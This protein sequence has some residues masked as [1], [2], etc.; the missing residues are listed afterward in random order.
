[1][2]SAEDSKIK[3]DDYKQILIW[4]FIL[5][6]GTDGKT[7]QES[8]MNQVN[9][10]KCLKSPWKL[11][12]DKLHHIKGQ[13]KNQSELERQYEYQEFVYFH[14]FVSQF[15]F[16]KHDVSDDRLPAL[17]IFKRE[18][19]R[20][21]EVVLA[22]GKKA[23]TLS[24]D[25]TNLYFFDIGVA[26]LV[27]ELS[28]QE[29]LEM[30]DVMN[31][32]NQLRRVYP[33][34][35]EGNDASE[36]PKNVKW[37]KNICPK[38][39]K[40]NPSNGRKDQ[41]TDYIEHVDGQRNAP[42][43]PHWRDLLEPLSFGGYSK[44]PS[45]KDVDKCLSGWRQIVDER[46]PIMT[47]IGTSQIKDI[48]NGDWIRL[49][50]VDMPDESGKDTLPYGSKF[51]ET[52]E[53][54]HMYDRFWFPENRPENREET[55]YLCAGYSFLTVA[56][57][58]D[59]FAEKIKTIHFRRQYFQIGLIVHLQMAA[60]LAISGYLSNVVREFHKK[61]KE[62]NIGFD[63]FE[64]GIS[65][66]REEFL[67]FTHCYWF[68]GVS[69][70]VQGQEIYDLWRKN[71]NM[72][73]L[74]DEVVNELKEADSFLTL[75]RQEHIAERQS[76][77]ADETKNLTQLAAVG[78]PMALAVGFLGM[79]LVVGN[80]GEPSD[81]SSLNQWYQSFGVF[82]VFSC[83]GTIMVGLLYLRQQQEKLSFICKVWKTLCRWP[84]RILAIL[85]LFFAAL[86]VLTYLIEFGC[87]VL[88][89]VWGWLLGI[90][91][92]LKLL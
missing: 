76:H 79:N 82:A 48:S 58:E 72:Q 53:A 46:I 71:L 37:L 35:W 23:V 70:Q 1:M 34:Y 63:V 27:V 92:H 73:V 88:P 18:D 16:E 62:K 4:P 30:N 43:A 45:G 59:K 60:L 17:N 22:E 66:L 44:T 75:R 21:A 47:Y 42:V 86:F 69:N 57:P 32:S 61:G 67:R 49:C 13:D 3:E 15:L 12:D 33:P 25:R 83:I 29:K 36:F 68:T 85:T 90:G 89:K 77:I 11:I 87:T 54:N 8:V 64:N 50:C 81:W 74:Y 5:D 38:G 20:F 78:L 84:V 28:N 65:K 40:T 19:I 7:P 6:W 56:S 2:H 41:K 91:S 10:L 14:N 26:V 51:L 31:I 52:F 55:R 39:E 24:V 80:N 9:H